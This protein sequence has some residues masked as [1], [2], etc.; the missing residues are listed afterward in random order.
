MCHKRI[1]TVWGSS[2]KSLSLVS[3]VTA[4]LCLLAIV[5]GSHERWQ[6]PKGGMGMSQGFDNLG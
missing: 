4:C 5:R 6:L 1:T 3:K 2:A